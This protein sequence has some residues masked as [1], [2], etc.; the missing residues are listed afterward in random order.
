MG[1]TDEPRR[2]EDHHR[3]IEALEDREQLGQI[4]KIAVVEGEQETRLAIAF[5][6]CIAV[7]FVWMYRIVD[8][9]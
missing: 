6:D 8:A 5:R 2:D 3:H 1:I 7:E 9:Q 4:V